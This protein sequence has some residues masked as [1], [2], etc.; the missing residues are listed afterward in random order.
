MRLTKALLSLL[1]AAATVTALAQGG[2][3]TPEQDP[4]LQRRITLHAE[5]E[6][7]SNIFRMLTEQGVNLMIPTKMLEQAETVTITVRDQP[8]GD[9]MQ[10]LAAAVRGYWYK[11]GE[12]FVFAPYPYPNFAAAP[13]GFISPQSNQVPQPIRNQP[14]QAVNPGEG[15]VIAVDTGEMAPAEAAVYV[16]PTSPYSRLL[17]SITPAQWERMWKRGYLRWSELSKVQRAMIPADKRSGRQ[18]FKWDGRRLVVR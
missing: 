8:I 2:V 16:A 11:H 3:A 1:A 6:K 15:T 14:V 5:N 7:L 12:I 17:N 18:T 4:A 9:F 13:P 10:A